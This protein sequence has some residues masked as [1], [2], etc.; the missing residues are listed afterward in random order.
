[1]FRVL[2]IVGV[3]GLASC[4]GDSPAG[5]GSAQSPPLPVVSTSGEMKMPN[6]L[7]DSVTNRDLLDS[8]GGV[9]GVTHLPP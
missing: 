9:V 1:M 7:P 6:S 3:T 8:S 4:T 5:G 2:A